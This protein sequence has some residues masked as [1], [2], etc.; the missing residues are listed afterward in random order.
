M[1]K[2]LWCEEINCKD[3]A[4]VY[5]CIHKIYWCEA[6]AEGRPPALLSV[7]LP[8]C[9]GRAHAQPRAGALALP[10]AGPGPAPGSAL[11]PRRR[12]RL[13]L[14][15][16][17]AGRCGSRRAAGGAQRRHV[18]STAQRRRRGRGSAR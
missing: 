1:P 16:A 15:A 4:D 5:N 11:G 14:P 18:G 13:S 9:P 6:S 10:R 2:P 12:H 17:A 3:K 7:P 8:V